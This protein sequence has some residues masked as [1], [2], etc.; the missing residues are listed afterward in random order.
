[1]AKVRIVRLQNKRAVR[2]RNPKVFSPV[3]RT[4]LRGISSFDLLQDIGP[5]VRVTP[6]DQLSQSP[7]WDLVSTQ[8]C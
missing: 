6:R 2:M 7:E 4:N 5:H 1:M 3:Q 8:M